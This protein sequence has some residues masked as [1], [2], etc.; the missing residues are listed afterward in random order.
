MELKRLA[1]VDQCEMAVVYDD[2]PARDRAIR[3]CDSLV[4]RF[5]QDPAFEFSWWNMRYLHD[6]EL[7]QL[8]AQAAEKADLVLFSITGEVEPSA[9]VQ[10]WVEKWLRRRRGHEGALVAWVKHSPEHKQRTTP[11]ESYLRSVARRAQMDYLPVGDSAAADQ[12]LPLPSI[13]STNTSSMAPPPSH[14]G[15][16]E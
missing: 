10:Q 6:P 15:L 11:L 12:S 14:W 7:A 3:L 2:Q 5:G 4:T 13:R 9:E 8:A 1:S 16:N